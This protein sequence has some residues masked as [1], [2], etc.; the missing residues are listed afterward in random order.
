MKKNSPKEQ[1]H[2]KSKAA[3]EGN[4]V[5]ITLHTTSF[6][7]YD[8]GRVWS[9]KRSQFRKHQIDKD[10]YHVLGVTIYEDKKYKKKMYKIHRLVLTHFDREPIGSEVCRHLDGNTH[11]NHISN[12][13]WGSAKRNSADRKKH[14]TDCSGETNVF[15]KFTTKD[16][17]TIRAL[18]KKHRFKIG[19]TTFS[20]RVV[21]H[22][23]L[24]VEPCSILDI[25]QGRSWKH[26]TKG[27]DLIQEVKR[28]KLLA[29]NYMFFD[30]K[31]SGM[32]NNA[33]SIKYAK[34]NGFTYDYV[35]NVIR[36]YS[37]SGMCPCRFM[38]LKINSSGI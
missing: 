19:T 38:D 3:P 6:I 35:Y 7:L 28:R 18:Y 22:L 21:K 26:I 8:D 37:K 32:S 17:K 9:V 27:I 12:L 5:A 34:E 25:I 31:R 20:A 10:G 13:K 14:G 24:D 1:T 15:A 30:Y 36:K 29:S 4:S 11:N 33:F 2:L 16:I 23:N